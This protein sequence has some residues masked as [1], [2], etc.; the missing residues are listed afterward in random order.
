MA[1]Q[2]NA[3]PLYF[4]HTHYHT[5]RQRG[6]LNPPQLVTGNITH[7]NTHHTALIVCMWGLIHLLLYVRPKI[8]IYKLLTCK[9]INKHLCNVSSPFLGK[10]NLPY[11]SNSEA[12]K[13][14]FTGVSRF[15]VERRCGVIKVSIVIT[16]DSCA[17]LRDAINLTG[18]WRWC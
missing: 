14:S 3:C 17:T 6:H 5:Q 12:L 13:A 18:E 16:K 15:Q 10:N 2:P 11:L 4:Q 9:F 8:L 7:A 1:G